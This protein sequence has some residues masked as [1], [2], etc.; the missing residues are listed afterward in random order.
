MAEVPATINVSLAP[1]LSRD[2]YIRGVDALAAAIADLK[3]TIVT[4]ADRI[5]AGLSNIQADIDRL[6]QSLQSARDEIAQ[7]LADQDASIAQAVDA[8]LAPVADQVEA[9]ASDEPEPTPEP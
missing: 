4:S 1:W 8:A 3:E 6:Q 2:E 5:T 7:I 9:L